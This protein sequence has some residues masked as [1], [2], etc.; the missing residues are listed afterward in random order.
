MQECAS[1]HFHVGASQRRSQ[2][3]LTLAAPGVVC[4]E[5]EEAGL[6]PVTASSVNVSFAAALTGH[7]AQRRV[8]VAVAQSTILGAVGVTVTCWGQQANG[9]VELLKTWLR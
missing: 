9:Q 4:A 7:Q 1:Q 6:A 8:G 2:C 3:V 5:T